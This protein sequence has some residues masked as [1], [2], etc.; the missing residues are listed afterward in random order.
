MKSAYIW[1]SGFMDVKTPKIPLN[2]TEF[3]T[4][5]ALI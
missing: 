4:S 1:S 2:V 3:M 5:G